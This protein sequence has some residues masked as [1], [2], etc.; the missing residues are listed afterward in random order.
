MR[1]LRLTGC[2]TLAKGNNLTHLGR[3]YDGCG[4]AEG[5]SVG[6]WQVMVFSPMRPF[7]RALS[8]TQ[9]RHYRCVCWWGCC[10]AS[11]GAELQVLWSIV[12]EDGDRV[13][14]ADETD[15]F[16]ASCSGSPPA[17]HAHTM[18]LRPSRCSMQTMARADRESTSSRDFP[19]GLGHF[20]ARTRKTAR[21]GS[22]SRQQRAY[23]PLLPASTSQSAR[24]T[25]VPAR[26]LH[27]VKGIKFSVFNG[28]RVHRGGPSTCIEHASSDSCI[29][30]T[31][32]HVPFQLRGGK[33]RMARRLEL[34]DVHT[35]CSATLR[36][37]SLCERLFSTVHTGA[38]PG[39]IALATLGRSALRFGSKFRD[40]PVCTSFLLEVG[41]PWP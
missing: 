22:D 12:G 23:N 20:K 32:S 16:A 26:A 21:P 30:R 10:C 15:L 33:A 7:A 34:C 14:C 1:S 5:R 40:R 38:G 4:R 11:G 27:R 2:W 28:R 36:A 41:S 24:S 19:A 13:R 35:L 3:S 8:V 25:H 17:E 9:S 6:R 31:P 39:A 29:R 18:P 37:P